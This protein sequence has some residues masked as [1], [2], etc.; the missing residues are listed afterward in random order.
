MSSPITINQLNPETA[1]AHL[2]RIRRERRLAQ[3]FVKWNRSNV[4]QE[5]AELWQSMF[6]MARELE[7][8]NGT[9]TTG[10]TRAAD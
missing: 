6:A 4:P 2:E 5:R 9:T 8:T 1:L 7:S 3:T 10:S